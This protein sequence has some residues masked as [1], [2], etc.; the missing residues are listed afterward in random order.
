MVP[1]IDD[2]PYLDHEGNFHA[3]V[4]SFATRARLE[5]DNGHADNYVIRRH[6]ASQSLADENLALMD[7]WLAALKAD[8]SEMSMLEKIVKARPAALQDDCFDE[9]GERIVEKAVYDLGRLFDNTGSRC[10]ALYPP[11]AGLR[12]VAG[13][14]MSN[15]VLK[16]QLKPIDYK[17]YAVSFSDAEKRRLETIFAQGVCDWSKPGVHQTTNQ[18]WLS[19]GPSPVNRYLPQ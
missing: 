16:C 17:D 18:T 9:N 13:G 4:Y 6:P 2:R 5:R 7:E 11:H 19:F 8:R 12:L 1:I 3:S 14:P 15:D 10:N